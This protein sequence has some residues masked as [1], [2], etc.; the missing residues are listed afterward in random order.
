M[1]T[2]FTP[3]GSVGSISASFALT[4]SI[5][6]CG[7]LAEAHDHDAADGFASAV[8]S[9]TPRRMS[10]PKVTVATSRTSTG[11][12]VCGL[13]HHDDVRECRPAT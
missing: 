8:E 13:Y 7:V 4:R 10:G 11:V 2:I 12:P 9:T 1:V 3:A 5:T 6:F